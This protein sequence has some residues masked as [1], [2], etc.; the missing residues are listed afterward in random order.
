MNGLE[1]TPLQR[2]GFLRRLSN[3]PEKQNAIIEIK[4]LLADNPVTSISMLQVADILN[5]YHVGFSELRPEF[6]EI[7]HHIL[8]HVLLQCA[9]GK[10][11]PRSAYH[12]IEHLKSVFELPIDLP[13]DE[14]TRALLQRFKPPTQI[15]S[16]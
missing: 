16:S 5:R 7:V 11:F 8:R 4:N 12:D 14:E 3:R 1:R 2:T 13:F 9:E 6:V 15:V 10:T